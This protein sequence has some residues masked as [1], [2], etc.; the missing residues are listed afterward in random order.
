MPSNGERPFIGPSCA[1]AGAFF[2]QK[3]V[4]AARLAVLTLGVCCLWGKLNVRTKTVA[5]RVDPHIRDS[6]YPMVSQ[7]GSPPRALPA[8]AETV[9]SPTVKDLCRIAMVVPSPSGVISFHR[10]DQRDDIHLSDF[11]LPDRSDSSLRHTGVARLRYPSIF[12]ALRYRRAGKVGRSSP[13]CC[14]SP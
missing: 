12:P 6:T 7:S 1:A 14:P 5:I 4:T 13:A 11:H 3:G 2:A 10:V 9:F 8:N